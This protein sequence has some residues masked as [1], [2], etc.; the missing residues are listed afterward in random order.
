MT[1]INT[2]PRVQAL[3]QLLTLDD[4]WFFLTV[5]GITNSRY[6][7]EEDLLK[8]AQWT[9]RYCLGRS[10]LQKN[11]TMRI[12]GSVEVG[13][14]QEGLHAHLLINKPED[15]RRSDQ[16]LNNFIR[17]RW[18]KLSGAKGRVAGNLVHFEK[19]RDFQSVCDYIMKTVRSS[20][21]DT[22]LY[23]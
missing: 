13:G 23:I 21:N 12:F 19:A 22:L 9:N 4:N 7:F 5:N 15:V 18:L 2:E 8:I 6:R 3:K 10:Y 17:T 20:Q 11:K 16:E 1:Y 14:L